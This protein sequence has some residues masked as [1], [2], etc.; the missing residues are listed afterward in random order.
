MNDDV[1]VSTAALLPDRGGEMGKGRPLSLFVLHFGFISM[2]NSNNICT[3]L[4]IVIIFKKRSAFD[5]NLLRI[6]DL[7]LK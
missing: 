6:P 7:R 3:K 2:H 4:N 1:C 5:S